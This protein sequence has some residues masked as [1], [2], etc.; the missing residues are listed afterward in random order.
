MHRRGREVINSAS[1][2]SRLLPLA[3][4]AGAVLLGAATTYAGTARIAIAASGAVLLLVIAA[5]DTTLGLYALVVWLTALGMIRRLTTGISAS[6]NLGDPLLLVGPALLITLTLVACRRGALRDRSRL[7]TGVIVLIAALTCSILNPSQ[8]GIEVGLGGALLVVPPMLAFFIGRALVSDAVLRRVLWIY[9]WL[10]LGA[11]AYGLYQTFVGFP[12]WDQR[13]I[14]ESGYTALHINDVVRAFGNF[15]SSAEYA[16]FLSIGLVCW[17][18]LGPRSRARA[19]VVPATVFL[20]VA[21][22]YASARGVVVLLLVAVALMFVARKR[23]PMLRG[24]L[25]VLVALAAFPTVLAILVPDQFGTNPGSQ[26]AAHQ[27]IGLTD[28]FGSESTLPSHL[29]FATD[30]VLSAIHHPLGLG[31]GAVTTAST[32]LASDPTAANNLG[33]SE[34]DFGNAAIATG[35]IG[36]IA[37]LFVAVVGLRRA[38]TSVLLERN[39]LAIAALGVLAATFF[40]WLNGG[41][42][43]VAIAPWLL[44]GWLDR[45]NPS[46]AAPLRSVAA[47][48][49][50][51]VDAAPSRRGR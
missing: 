50:S 1:R 34:V 18:T 6:F 2:G 4:G 21:I 32:K 43:A 31:V 40:Q 12:S 37:Y 19:L 10:S 7:T 15:A 44:L 5:G 11:A 48:I 25:L 49:S 13:W 27:A 33:G 3:I 47:G 17:L 51:D 22:W 46:G 38:Y 23:M 14:D 45:A 20:L 29:H 9:A 35:I 28:P 24:F 36:L 39:P 30:G 26:L 42:Y 8:G 16:M 41:Q